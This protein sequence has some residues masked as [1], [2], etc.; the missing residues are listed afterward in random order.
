[1]LNIHYKDLAILQNKEA[2]LKL[3]HFLSTAI[4]Q[5]KYQPFTCPKLF[6][7]ANLEF[8]RGFKTF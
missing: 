7:Y 2:E 5:I 3:K 6:T 8:K 4:I 1:M